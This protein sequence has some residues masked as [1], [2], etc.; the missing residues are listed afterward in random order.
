MESGPEGEWFDQGR[1]VDVAGFEANDLRHHSAT[2]LKRWW[3]ENW[4]QPIARI[5]EV[6]NYE[7]VLKPADPLPDHFREVPTSR[8]HDT[9]RCRAGSKTFGLQPRRILGA[10]NWPAIS[11]SHQPNRT[12]ISDITADANGELFLYVNDAVLTLPGLTDMFY[13]NNSGKA[14]VTVTQVMADEIIPAPP[15]AGVQA[16]LRDDSAKPGD[17]PGDD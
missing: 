12:L 1:R 6:G 3:R 15:A 16:R 2:P 11:A 17:R 4:F 14:K 9:R 8:G 7:H 13:K 10:S 5:G